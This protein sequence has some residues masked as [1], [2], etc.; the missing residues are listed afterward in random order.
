MGHSSQCLSCGFNFQSKV[1]TVNEV[2]KE[3]ELKLISI[4]DYSNVQFRTR[5]KNEVREDLSP[6]LPSVY[7]FSN[8]SLTDCDCVSLCGLASSSGLSLLSHSLGWLT[9]WTASLLRSA[10]I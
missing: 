7:F 10:S 6:F 9:C 4:S 1:E 2:I 5:I 3:A 8:S